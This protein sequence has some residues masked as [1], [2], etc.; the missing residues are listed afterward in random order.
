[1]KYLRWILLAFLIFIVF[2]SVREGFNPA[3]ERPSV[4]DKS[5]R[6][7][8]TSFTGSSDDVVVG[9]YITLLGD[10]YDKVYVPGGKKSPTPDEKTK[11]V[12]D[13]KEE[14]DIN[15]DKVGQLIDY[16]FLSVSSEPLPAAQN[17]RKTGDS[18]RTSGGTPAPATQGTTT[19]TTTGGSTNALGP[20][21]VTPNPSGR[22]VWGPI[23]NGFGAS[24]GAKNGDST[25]SNKY[26][27]LMGPNPKPSTRIEGVGVVAPSKSY[28]LTMDGALPSAEQT[29]SD[30]KSQFFP[31]SRTPGDQDL[32]PDPYRVA[33]TFSAS[34]YASRPAPT[35][36]LADFSA[37]Q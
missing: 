28:Q 2:H 32:I 12:G 25:S 26:P 15:K 35:P 31:Y 30:E 9:K 29:G 5:L 20:T 10:F 6:A 24:T 37:F 3:Q 36:F 18:P 14:K 17:T 27:T 21:N 23:F 16:V 13:L 1:M 7:T 4:T 8:V 11:F 22:D 34:N 33:Q 19:G